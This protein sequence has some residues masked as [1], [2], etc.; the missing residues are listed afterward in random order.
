MR[1]FIQREKLDTRYIDGRDALVLS[2][3]FG[4]V[5]SGGRE[6]VIRLHNM[7][8]ATAPDLNG[9]LTDGGSVP[10]FA[11]PIVGHPFGRWLPAFICH[12]YDF[13]FRTVS[14][15]EAND[16]LAEALDCLGCGALTRRTIV[17][18]VQRFGRGIW[19][20]GAASNGNYFWHYGRIA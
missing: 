2:P 10:R 9:F 20:R 17:G 5:T 12:D 7:G 6:I 18:C 11:W 13:S 1:H 19:Q 15:E 3:L 14:F 16:T 8:T 4:F